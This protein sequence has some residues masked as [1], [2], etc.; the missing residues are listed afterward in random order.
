MNGIWLQEKQN[1]LLSTC[2][3]EKKKTFIIFPDFFHIWKIALQIS[4]L[5]LYQEFKTLYEPTVNE[6]DIQSLELKSV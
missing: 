5:R 6:N 4:W 2:S 1:H 3:Y